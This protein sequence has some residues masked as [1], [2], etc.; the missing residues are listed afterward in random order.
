MQVGDSTGDR[1][2]HPNEINGRHRPL[3]LLRRHRP[4][5]SQQQHR[6]HADR[7]ATHGPPPPPVSCLLSPADDQ[8]SIYGLEEADG[9]RA[10]VLELVEGPTLA[11]RIKQGPS[12]LDEAL[13]IMKQIAEALE[14]AHEQGVIHR[15]LKPANIKVGFPPPDG[16]TCG[17]HL[18]AAPRRSSCV[19]VE[20]QLD[21][22]GLELV[23]TGVVRSQRRV[24][25]MLMAMRN[26]VLPAVTYIVLMSGPPKARLVMVFCGI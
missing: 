26:T 5:P 18:F 6:D 3:A 8:W 1:D 20:G 24:P 12:P 14:A 11:D 7:C 13:P 9:I 21:C 16:F 15:D 10:L 25:A 19:T 22:A 23:R 17:S 2:L 4:R